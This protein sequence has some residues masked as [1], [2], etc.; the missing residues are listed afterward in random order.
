MMTIQKCRVQKQL[1]YV[2]FP[3]ENCMSSLFFSF[4]FSSEHWRIHYSVYQAKLPFKRLTVT[5]VSEGNDF[6]SSSEFEKIAD[7]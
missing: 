6:I 7:T 3:P 2:A 1:A 4:F 5:S